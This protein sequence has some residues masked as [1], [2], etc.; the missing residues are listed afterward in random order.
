LQDLYIKTKLI[1]HETMRY[2]DGVYVS[3]RTTDWLTEWL[4]YRS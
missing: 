2:I 4:Y 1:H 3:R